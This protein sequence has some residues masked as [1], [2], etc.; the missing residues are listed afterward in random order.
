VNSSSIS[1]VI[2]VYQCAER[3]PEH[4]ASLRKLRSLVHEFIWVITI[5]QDGSH[6]IAREAARELGGQ[7]LEVPRGLY[8]AWNFGIA[9]ATGEFVYFS[10]VGD[11][12]SPEGLNELVLCIQKNQADVV[13]SPPVIS[14]PTQAN[15]KHCRH[16]TVFVFSKILNRFNEAR[17]PNEKTFLL[18]ILSGASGLLGSCASC[19]FRTSFLQVRPFP[20]DYHHYGDT[21]WT[22]HNLPEAIIAFHPNPVARF[23]IH[24]AKIP[25][26]VDKG[27]IYNLSEELALQLPPQ[28]TRTTH[29]YI[30]ASQKIDQI[31]DPHPKF[32]W[33][34]MP[35]AWIARWKRN[36]MKRA[37]VHALKLF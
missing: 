5:S 31:R 14:P 33:W 8:Q 9:Q 21:A 7:I 36:K 12:I 16:W 18:Q 34:W 11:T 23:V 26:I 1:V 17:I 10:T 2:P 15:L 25:R 32:G 6:Q 37:L 27:Q 28:L 19:L 13:F 29:E 24:N 3:L 22:F 20:T 35:E 4:V 30:Q